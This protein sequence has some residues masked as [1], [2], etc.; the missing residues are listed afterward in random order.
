[1]KGK[2]ENGKENE[3]PDHRWICP[4]QNFDIFLYLDWY[5]R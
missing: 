1:M 4:L 3:L 2:G 5:K